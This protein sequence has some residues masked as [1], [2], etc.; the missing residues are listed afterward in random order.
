MRNRFPFY[1]QTESADCGPTCLRMIAKFYGKHYNLSYLKDQSH[2]TKMGVSLQGLSDAAHAIGMRS[3]AV[4]IDIKR[5][6]EEAPLPCIVHWKQRH[7][8]VLYKVKKGKYYV[9]DPA[10]GLLVY[11]EEEFLKGWLGEV[12]EDVPGH[13]LL[14]ETTPEFFD[15]DGSK[16][17]ETLGLSY[18]L[19]YL[20]PYKSFIVQLFLG[21]VAGS[22]L[23]LIFPFLTQSIVDRGIQYNDINFVYLML[24]GQLILF[25]SETAIRFIRSWILLH[26]STRI[27][28]SLISDFLAKM[29]RLPISYFETRVVG[30]TLQ[31]IGDHDRIQDF[32]TNSTLSVLFSTLNF[33]VFGIV[34]AF[35]SWEIFAIFSISTILYFGWI[36]IFLKKRKELDY[37]QFDQMS[38]NQSTLV[39][40]V[41]AMQDIKLN[42]Y[43][44]EKRWEWERIQARL[45]KISVEGLK[46]SQYQEIGAFFV[47]NLKDILITFFAAKA[48]IDGN[49]TLGTMLA[50]QYIIGQ[51]NTPLDDMVNFVQAAQDAKISLDRLNEIRL[52]QDEEPIDTPKLKK[53]PKDRSLSLRNVDFSYRGA[54]SGLVLKNINL[55]IP[56]GNVVAIVGAS[57][58]GKTTLLKLLL[59]FFQPIN[60]TV[61]LGKQ[62]LNNYHSDWWRSQCGTVM[63]DGFIYSNTILK[64]IVAGNDNI[65]YDRVLYALEA[66]NIEEFVDALPQGIHTKI[67]TEG[68]G[69]SQGQKQ[70]ILIARA[71]YKNP[72]YLF[73]DEA[74]SA[75][76]A[77]NEKIIMQ[78][79]DRFSEG[80]TVV[81]VAHRL[82]TVMNA[83]KIIVLH[84][85]EIVEEGT[86]QELTYRR[87]YYFSLVKNQLELGV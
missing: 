66:A 81:V 48:V 33:V 55:T 75:L 2:I 84:N 37:K 60:G 8:I 56:E 26:I 19:G 61:H 45:F 43:E 79:L 46:L 35:F 50:I 20:K 36:T 76:D 11:N 3:L 85:G 25:L 39:E 65:D 14:L 77:N 21:M 54:N 9:A 7:F 74:T 58:S 63:Q 23:M 13:I 22:V 29:M 64:N 15:R 4:G 17:S 32:M 10:H 62:N 27:N 42:N 67:G 80:K 31:R 53:L 5:L 73:F 18:W 6:S 86:H 82:S 51:V 41:S 83:D 47:K 28:I 71:V 16:N 57:G 12:K 44:K 40:L 24:L 59:K 78:N 52:K 1:R 68:V 70:R 72:K 87:G 30:D 69:I 38:A 34:L 49:M